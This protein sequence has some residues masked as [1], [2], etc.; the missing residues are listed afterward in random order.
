MQALAP[1]QEQ[2]HGIALYGEA[3][4][5]QGA[6]R[7][8]NG[9]GAV[10]HAHGDVI[11]RR[12]D[13]DGLRL[14]LLHGETPFHGGLVEV[15]DGLGH[16]LAVVVSIE[17]QQLVG[18]NLAGHTR[19]GTGHAHLLWIEI[20]VGSIAEREQQTGGQFVGC[21]IESRKHLV[22]AEAQHG[23]KQATGEHPRT[24]LEQVQGLV[25]IVRLASLVYTSLPGG[26]V[27]LIEHVENL[28]QMVEPLL[29]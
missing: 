23:G 22:A 8:L 13:V 29:A 28:C 6:R 9:G 1:M 21:L 25:G 7:V 26:E 10:A 18:L 16:R 2:P 5:H 3:R 24:L 14:G 17:C 4:A 20:L 19:D 12:V 27:L 15:V 11:Q